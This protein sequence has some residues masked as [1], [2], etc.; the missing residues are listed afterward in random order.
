MN[1]CT[2]HYCLPQH[3]KP[4]YN[5]S[6]NHLCK[7]YC[8]FLFSFY[9][10]K[11]EIAKNLVQQSLFCFNKAATELKKI[12]SKFKNSCSEVIINLNDNNRDYVIQKAAKSFRHHVIR[13]A[14]I[15]DAYYNWRRS[16]L[17][18]LATRIEPKLLNI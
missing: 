18:F 8:N 15:P 17:P 9:Q 14:S 3:S 11:K 16:V 2:E 13:N 4:L 6:L 12:F 7:I 5:H 10:T 1:F